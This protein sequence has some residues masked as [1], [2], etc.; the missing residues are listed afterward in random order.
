MSGPTLGIGRIT[1]PYTVGGL[2]HEC[3]MFVWNPTLAGSVYN[4]DIHPDFGG[5]GNWEDFAQGLA[6]AISWLLA[7]GTTPGVAQLEELQATGWVGLDSV[8]VTFPNLAGSA[9]PATQNTYTLRVTDNSRPKIVIME[10]NTIGPQRI[11]SPTAGSAAFD[12]FFDR[13]EGSSIQAARPYQ[14]MVNQHG[15]WLKSSPFAGFHIS[16][17]RKLER[18]RGL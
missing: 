10:G 15:F 13:F 8:A 6:E 11:A 12:N 7:T 9:F 5:V 2:A 3:R 14:C 1:I 16:Y 17:N 18:A 4:I